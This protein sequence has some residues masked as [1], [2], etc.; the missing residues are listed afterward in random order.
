MS[1]GSETGSETI[2]EPAQ[3]ACTLPEWKDGI[4]PLYVQPCA[5]PIVHLSDRVSSSRCAFV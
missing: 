4:T 1:T 5:Q 3:E 2:T